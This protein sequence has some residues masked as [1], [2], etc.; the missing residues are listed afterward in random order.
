MPAFASRPASTT[1]T[2]SGAPSW[3]AS[4]R[5]QVSAECRSQSQ[6]CPISVPPSAVASGSAANALHSGG[7]CPPA[8]AA[9]AANMISVRVLIARTSSNFAPAPSAMPRISSR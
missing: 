4:S 7:S 8:W 1:V 5:T 9:L 6:F 2:K 3:M